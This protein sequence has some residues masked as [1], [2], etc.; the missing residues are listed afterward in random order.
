MLYTNCT[1]SAC[2]RPRCPLRCAVRCGGAAPV[3]L[4][5]CRQAQPA[6]RTPA[7]ASAASMS[8]HR[9]DGP[10]LQGP[11]VALGDSPARRLPSIHP[12][13]GCVWRAWLTSVEVADVGHGV[14]G[15]QDNL[16]HP[17]SQGL[18]G[19]RRVGCVHGRP[20]HDGR[21]RR[22]GSIHTMYC[23][24]CRVS[25][26]RVLRDLSSWG[27]PRC[28]HHARRTPCRQPRLPAW[29]R[30]SPVDHRGCEQVFPTLPW[31]RSPQHMAAAVAA[32]S[33]PGLLLTLLLQ[34][35]RTLS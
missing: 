23:R 20:P 8:A 2:R 18:Q 29:C 12:S 15:Q 1:V 4:H 3:V 16:C 28:T 6:A 17:G 21:C 26:L 11:L 5:C 22:M 9:A 32:Q 24:Q 14:G 27:A 35:P 33:C 30:S 25:R 10:A 7:Q 13:T 19:V 31:P 34:P